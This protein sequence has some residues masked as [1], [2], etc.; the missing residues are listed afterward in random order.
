MAQLCQKGA[1]GGGGTHHVPLLYP[2]LTRSVLGVVQK[3]VFAVKN[4]AML[5]R[6]W[7]E[8][9]IKIMPVSQLDH[10]LMDMFIFSA[11]NRCCCSY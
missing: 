5:W 9:R 2:F 10:Y 6:Q 7:V 3:H 11:T 8:L 1:Q 4:T